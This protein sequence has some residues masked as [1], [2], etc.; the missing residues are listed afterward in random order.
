MY[1]CCGVFLS[2]FF[3]P[4]SLQPISVSATQGCAGAGDPTGSGST[5][6]LNVAKK[7]RGWK[8]CCSQLDRSAAHTHTQL[9]SI[10]LPSSQLADFAYADSDKQARAPPLHRGQGECRKLPKLSEWACGEISWRRWKGEE[11]YMFKGRRRGQW[12]CWRVH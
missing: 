9:L 8:F 11:E 6:L 7:G 1:I 12:I 4:L 2:C 3:L 10:L 5:T